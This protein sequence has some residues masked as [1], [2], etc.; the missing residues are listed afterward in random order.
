MSMTFNSLIFSWRPWLE[1]FNF[2]ASP[3]NCVTIRTASTRIAALSVF[4]GLPGSKMEPNSTNL[5]MSIILGIR[6]VPQIHIDIK[7]KEENRKT[8]GSWNFEV[9]SILVIELISS[10]F[11]PTCL[12]ARSS[13]CLRSSPAARNEQEN[14][15]NFFHAK[16]I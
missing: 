6:Y 14:E 15:D 1:S 8:G 4:V 3:R 10:Q 2:C 12:G 16:A 5:T 7:A 9:E 13:T 11:L